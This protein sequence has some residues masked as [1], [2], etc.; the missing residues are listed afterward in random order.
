MAPDPA[1]REH[2]LAEMGHGY[3]QHL[4]LVLSVLAVLLI[5]SMLGAA[6]GARKG[7]GGAK[8]GAW[9]FMVVGPLCFAAQEH[10]ERALH[11]AAEWGLILDPGASGS[12]SPSSSSPPSSPGPSRRCSS[13]QRGTLERA[14]F[15]W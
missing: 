8:L 1:V 9:P 5:A 14:L 3:L 13:R 4:A 15:R 10:V 11:G 12:V 2:L 7:R 6:L